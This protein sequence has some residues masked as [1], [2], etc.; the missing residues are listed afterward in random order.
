MHIDLSYYCKA[1][2]FAENIMIQQFVCESG[3]NHF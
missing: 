1:F 3:D 2:K